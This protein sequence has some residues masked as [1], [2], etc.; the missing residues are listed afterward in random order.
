MGKYKKKE[1]KQN[2]KERKK[3]T[4]RKEKSK[5]RKKKSTKRKKKSK[6]RKKENKYKKKKETETESSFPFVRSIRLCGQSAKQNYSGNLNVSEEN[7][8]ANVLI[9]K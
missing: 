2:K 1:K 9:L 7:L 4:K 6:T 3:S 5:T 8:F